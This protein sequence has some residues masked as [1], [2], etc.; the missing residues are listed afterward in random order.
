M[1]WDKVGCCEDI[2]ATLTGIGLI[3]R[4]YDLRIIVSCEDIKAT[5]TGN[6]NEESVRRQ[7]NTI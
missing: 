1:N 2:E 3:I 6:S 4:R 5:F 7:V